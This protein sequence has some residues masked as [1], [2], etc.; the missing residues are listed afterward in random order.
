[1]IFSLSN[2]RP[3]FSKTD[4]KAVR[5][6]GH[7]YLLFDTL[8]PALLNHGRESCAVF[9]LFVRHSGFFANDVFLTHLLFVKLP[10]EMSYK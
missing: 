8:P 5:A 2:I 3:P 9:G 4:S 6:L 1:M 7:E 10:K